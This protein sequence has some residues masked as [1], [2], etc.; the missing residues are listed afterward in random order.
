MMKYRNLTLAAAVALG[1]ATAQGHEIR[2]CVFP[3]S[4]TRAVDTAVARAV[5]DHLALPYRVVDLDGTIG[6]GALPQAKLVKLLANKCDVFAGVPTADDAQHASPLRS[7][8][9]YAS[10]DFVEFGLPGVAAD[11]T[12]AVAYRTPAQLIAAEAKVPNFDVENTPAAV[13]DA[14]VDHRATRGI[15][16][17]PSLLAYQQEHA[18][19]RFTVTP[20]HS[21]L[22]HWDL[23]FVA[24]PRQGALLER[25]SRALGALQRSGRLQRLNAPLAPH[26]TSWQVG[27]VATSADAPNPAQRGWKIVRV[28]ATPTAQFAADQVGPGRKVYA[29]ECAKCH[30]DKMQ[31]RTA[32]ALVGPGFAPSSN[33]TMTVG[34]IYQYVTT[35]MPADKPG[36]LKPVQYVDVMAFLLRANGYAPSG[37]PMTAQAAGNDSSQFDS[38]VK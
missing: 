31:G 30:G 29:A 32:P 23:H 36:L 17:Y 4:P 26:R 8:R 13:I 9:A 10:A 19:T 27:A 34:G 21:R 1:A 22:S 25:V 18:G 28:S 3:H 7:S 35:N 24:A 2:L 6:N 37:K 38:F 15:A 12:V 11:G 33:S 14:V 20:V 16:W 5:F